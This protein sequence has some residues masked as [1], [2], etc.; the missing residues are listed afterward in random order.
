[1]MRTVRSELFEE[2]RRAK[3]F[4]DAWRDIGIAH[5]LL[6]G[7]ASTC[8][9]LCLLRRMGRRERMLLVRVINIVQG[10]YER[11]GWPTNSD[12]ARSPSAG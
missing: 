2:R 10:L 1:M 7:G 3:M 4:A 11:H 12:D 8:Q 6:K 9:M 5:A